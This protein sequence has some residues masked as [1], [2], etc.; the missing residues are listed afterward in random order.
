M[1]LYRDAVALPVHLE[2]HRRLQ[3]LQQDIEIIIGQDARDPPVGGRLVVQS[4][5]YAILFMNNA[6][7]LPGWKCC[8]A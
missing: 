7:E 4:H 8:P 2:V 5:L 1:L 6:G 3:R